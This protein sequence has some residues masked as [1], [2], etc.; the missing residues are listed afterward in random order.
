MIKSYKTKIK[1]NLEFSG[2]VNWFLSLE[3]WEVVGKL[4]Y[5]MYLVHLGVEYFQSGI[6]QSSDYFSRYSMVIQQ[7]NVI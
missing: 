2:P 5:S 7:E 1:I 4:S 6:M 3:I